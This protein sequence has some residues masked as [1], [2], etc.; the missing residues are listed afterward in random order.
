MSDVQRIVV[1]GGK[2]TVV[3]NGGDMHALRYGE[4]WKDLTGDKF[5]YCLATELLAARNALAAAW[6]TLIAANEAGL[7]TDTIWHSDS[8]TLFDF[9][10]NSLPEHVVPVAPDLPVEAAKAARTLVPGLPIEKFDPVKAQNEGVPE[11]WRMSAKASGQ[12]FKAFLAQ[13]WSEMQLRRHGYLERVAQ[14]TERWTFA[15]DSLSGLIRAVEPNGTVHNVARG[16][17]NTLAGR[18]MLDAMVRDLTGAQ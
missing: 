7:I 6:G 9:L 15:Y 3:I 13:G 11:G 14:P 17:M 8:E 2:Y 12:H 10:V 16:D 5:V 18:A 1:E 4:R